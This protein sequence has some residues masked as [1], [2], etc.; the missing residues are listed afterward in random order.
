MK[1]EVFLN[2]LEDPKGVK[3]IGVDELRELALAYPYSQVIQLLYGIRLR[4]SSEHLFNQQLGRA[5]ALS[6]DRSVLFEL[7]EDKPKADAPVSSLAKHHITESEVKP[8]RMAPKKPKLEEPSLQSKLSSPIDVPDSKEEDKKKEPST[9][10]KE[11]FRSEP[12]KAEPK[13]KVEYLAA[14]PEGLEKL[15]PKE[16]VKAILER[17]RQ[18]RQQFEDQKAGAPSEEKLFSE[19]SDNPKEETK[20]EESEV[21]SP[22]LDSKQ[23]D[24]STSKDSIKEE[25]I[26]TSEP[27]NIEEDSALAEKDEASE[28]PAVELEHFIQP[29]EVE[30]SS[31]V[32]SENE[33]EEKPSSYEDHPIDISDL[34]RR[35]YRERFESLVPESEEE[36]AE[37]EAVETKAEEDVSFPEEQV[38]PVSEDKEEVAIEEPFS[39]SEKEKL[40]NDTSTETETD[41]GMSVRIRGIRAR[42][43]RLRQEDAL[44]EEEMEALMDEHQ[45]LEELLSFLPAEDDRVFEVEVSQE[46]EELEAKVEEDSSENAS[47]ESEEIVASKEEETERE[48]H[49]EPAGEKEIVR[50]EEDE[51]E[52]KST[53]EDRNA[54]G[55]RS[56]LGEKTAAN[57]A[58]EKGAEEDHAGDLSGKATEVEKNS[59][60][61]EVTLAAENSSSAA[62]VEEELEDWDLDEQEENF[63]SESEEGLELEDEISRI[64]ALAERL[65]FERQG[66]V[67][68]EEEFSTQADE[69]EERTEKELKG[70]SKQLK[71]ENIE[72]SIE[73]EVSDLVQALEE[74]IAQ[75]KEE[76]AE[77]FEENFSEK[78]DQSQQDRRVIAAGEDSLEVKSETES[79]KEEAEE[80]YLQTPNYTQAKDEVAPSSGGKEAVKDETSPESG[81]AATDN[82]KAAEDDEGPSFG[83][84]LKRLNS[85]YEGD[86]A[87]DEV[88]KENS[89]EEENEAP[90][91]KSHLSEKIDLI[92]AF[93]EKLPDLKKRKPSKAEMV[94]AP[95]V[96]KEA[97]PEVEEFTLVTETLAK[98][99]IK[100]GHFKKAIQAYE[101]LRLKYP[102]KSSFFASR[103]SEIKK[104]SNSKK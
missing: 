66:N 67:S 97:E 104:L 36:S 23:Q 58:D 52:V 59:Q 55:A 27:E 91:L 39:E 83:T 101:I 81:P 78:G 51:Q 50:A 77:I 43:E 64:E 42:L 54:E 12:K 94:K 62:E 60:S 26:S 95:E 1:T 31:E 14:K 4:Y 17:N 100:Q 79:E 99:Y 3:K 24:Q 34:I 5:A 57:E 65:R 92:D 30:E 2:L 32:K 22:D 49:S 84:L 21:E 72:S 46:K 85:K 73:E 74:D 86:H 89:E 38:S 8:E 71:E 102:E 15:S 93:V 103:I 16:R 37:G 47:S 48:E 53:R 44:S 41:M 75:V 9:E 18:L 70:E 25:V 56:D 68:P 96:K 10:S 82:E 63:S 40:T 88:K 6:N 33:K 28:V 69:G 90:L 45:K 87:K 7:F 80:L 35:R 61:E 20:S 98:V 29:A 13:P 11:V 76:D 19:P